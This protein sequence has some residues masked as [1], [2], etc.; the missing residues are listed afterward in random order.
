M[1]KMKSVALS[2]LCICLSVYSLAQLEVCNECS[3]EKVWVSIAYK[4]GESWQSEGWWGIEEGRCQTVYFSPLKDS[5][6]YLYGQ[7]EEYIWSTEKFFFC[8]AVGEY[9]LGREDCIGSY[10]KGF[11]YLNTEGKSKASFTLTCGWK[12]SGTR[13]NALYYI[14][15]KPI[16]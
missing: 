4:I 10:R 9:I 6:Y 15:S 13:K 12:E 7:S 8:T 11:I 2:I 14:E 5:Q 1:I 3:E 16:R